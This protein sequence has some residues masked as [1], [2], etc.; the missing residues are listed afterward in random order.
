[1]TSARIRLDVLVLVALLSVGGA[2]GCGGSS[3]GKAA[4]RREALKSPSQII[5]D[6]AAA[7]GHVRS[8][9]L[10]GTGEDLRGGRII[11]SGDFG[12][13]GRLHLTLAQGSGTIEIILVGGYG[14]LKAN[15]AF[16]VAQGTQPKVVAFLADRWVKAAAASMPG[17][18]EFTTWTNPA[19]IGHCLVEK[20]LGTVSVAGSDTFAG[21]PVVIL[22]DHGDLPG[23]TRGR[24]YVAT[25]GPA[26][27]LRVVE[28][29]T[30]RPGGTP[31]RLCNETQISPS[32]TKAGDLRLSRYNQP[33][34]ITA[35]AGALDLK[36]LAG[37]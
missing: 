1:M 13:P 20:H 22:S 29:G 33:V 12:I 11:L 16:W 25:T 4:P 21:Q 17:M 2:V 6:A 15:R 30:K 8:F 36:A 24:L 35:P 19:T 5:A 9:H 7:L 3:G 34:S 27:P 23:S 32:T 28:T 14:Y 10:D 18:S 26:L 31:D 37:K